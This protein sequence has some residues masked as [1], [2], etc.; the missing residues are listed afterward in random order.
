MTLQTISIL[1][2]G[3]GLVIALVYYTL[4]LR[5][6]NRTLQ[7]QLLLQIYN[8]FDTPEKTKAIN[9]VFAWEFRD[10]D[11]YMEK[12]YSDYDTF[13]SVISFY[14]GVGVLV[15][16]RK[17]PIGDIYLMIG[18]FTILLWEKFEPIKNQIREFYN[19]PSWASETEYL[20]N[21]L[22]KYREKHPELRN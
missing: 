22:I 9:T 21:E 15:K 14:E 2:S 10:Y 12:Y 1:T 8:K 3:M 13:S 17:L 7:A 19:Y 20:Y 5:N 11:E 18:G 4:T 16:T 6:Q